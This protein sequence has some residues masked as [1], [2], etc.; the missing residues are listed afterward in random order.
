MRMQLTSVTLFVVGCATVAVPIVVP[1]S[2]AAQPT[3]SQAVV[4][5][6]A[7]MQFK[8]VA[9]GVSRAVLWGDPDTGAFGALTKF[10]AGTWKALHTHSNDI[11][12]VVITGAYIHEAGGKKTTVGPGSYML[13][14]G[15][16]PHASGAGK[17]QDALFLEESDG[18]FDLQFIEQKGK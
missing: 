8:D 3:G 6:A 1:R 17:G 16:E 9:P 7:H 11:R 10:K 18:K 13:V 4:M 14:P 15:G 12:I 2:A 5:L